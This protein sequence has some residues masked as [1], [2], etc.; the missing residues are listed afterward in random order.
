MASERPPQ[1][2][3]A[4]C[5]E[6]DAMWA[7]MRQ[8]A[9]DALR[10]DPA[11][12]PLFMGELLNRHSLEEA[13]IHRVSGRLGASAMDAATIADAFLAALDSEPTIGDAFRA[14]AAAYV[15]RDPACRRLIEPLLYFKGYHAI[16]ASRLA[17]ALWR[18]GKRDFAFY[19]QS[20][21]SDALAADIH[22]AAR[23]GKGIFLDHATG[24][25]VGET[26]V[27]ED[28]VSILHGVTL[29]GTGKVAGD[30]HP[31]IRRGVM[32]GADSKILGN[33]EIGQ[34]ARIAAGSVVLHPVPPNSVVAGVP[35]KVV[36]VEAAAEPARDMD[37]LLR[38]L[39]YDSFDYVI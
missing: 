19:I 33:I 30:R 39:A 20:R 24:F 18:A 6:R 29:G 32:I 17:H 15:E 35:A 5:A 22:P 9:E 12:A 26:A 27:V 16:Q 38:G 31:K 7:H 3:G 2:L 36:G 11:L 37:Q 13:V 21:A 25:V 34:R 28:D 4:L 23:F 10:L 8:E 14:D 1:E